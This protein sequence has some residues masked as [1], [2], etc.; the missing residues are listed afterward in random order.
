MRSLSF[1]FAGFALGFAVLSASASA[2]DPEAKIG[3]RFKEDRYSSREDRA[4][5]ELASFGDCVARMKREEFEAFMAQPTSDNWEKVMYFPNGQTRCLNTNMVAS[6]RSV[7][8]A[9]ADGWYTVTYKDGLAPSLASYKAKLPPQE[10]AIERIVAAEESEKPSVIVDEF[11]RCVASSA[12]ASVDRFLRTKVTSKEEKEAFSQL[13]PYLGPCA[14]EGQKLSF[15]MMG[16]RGAVAYALADLALNP[17]MYD[18]K[19]A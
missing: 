15:N 13:S 8:G 18:E 7:Q 17:T 9:I 19:G 3:S 14:F 16:F 5:L 10:P 12:P 2:Q 4:R 11:A 6:I 1:H